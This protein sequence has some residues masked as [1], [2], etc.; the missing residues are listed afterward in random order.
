MRVDW[1]LM[2][3]EPV[4]TGNRLEEVRVCARSG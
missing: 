4:A 3:F 1:V 2:L